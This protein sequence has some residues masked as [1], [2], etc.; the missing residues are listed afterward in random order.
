MPTHPKVYE[1]GDK[2]NAWIG[3]IIFQLIIYC[4]IYQS[5]LCHGR[6][7]ITL[8]CLKADKN[9]SQCVLLTAVVNAI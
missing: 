3:K 1:P 2:G 8:I 4:K 5:L 7:Q 9:H 6:L